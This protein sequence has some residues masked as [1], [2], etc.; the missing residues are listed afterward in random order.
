[1]LEVRGYQTRC[2]L[3][4]REHAKIFRSCFVVVFHC[5]AWL[6]LGGMQP[7]RYLPD[8]RTFITQS[9]RP[10]PKLE[11]GCT[12]GPPECTDER[13]LTFYWQCTRYHVECRGFSSAAGRA[14]VV[15]TARSAKIFTA[16]PTARPTTRLAARPEARTAATRQVPRQ[17]PRH[18]P[19]KD[20][21]Q[22][23][24]QDRWHIPRQALR[25]DPWID[26]WDGPRGEP[27]KH[28]RQVPR[29]DPWTGPRG[30]VYGKFLGRYC[31]RY[32]GK[33]NGKTRPDTLFPFFTSIP[34]WNHPLCH[35]ALTHKGR[36]S[37]ALCSSRRSPTW[38]A[39]PIGPW[40][41][42]SP[43][44]FCGCFRR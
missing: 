8:R 11:L 28:Q 40:R 17:H 29:K 2:E 22:A 3:H 14:K 7:R 39:S 26:P 32:R 25:I 20:P 31:G 23:R 33:P 43:V 6:W 44:R 15:L 16:N 38:H 21:R 4:R 34:Q 27:L 1:M 37:S 41:E 10:G 12:R 13:Y 42:S 9:T 30:Q 35:L 24:R 19:R 18:V 36:K 5:P